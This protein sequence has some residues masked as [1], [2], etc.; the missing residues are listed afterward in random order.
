MSV[1]P[2]PAPPP[3]DCSALTGGEETASITAPPANPPTRIRRGKTGHEGSGVVF[4]GYIKDINVTLKS[5]DINFHTAIK[6]WSN[7]LFYIVE[8]SVRY[9]GTMF[10]EYHKAFAAKAATI[11]SAACYIPGSHNAADALS[12]QQIFLA[13]HIS[14]VGSHNISRT[15]PSSAIPAPSIPVSFPVFNLLQSARNYMSAAL[16][17]SARSSCSTGWSSFSSFC[18]KKTHEILHLSATTIKSY[19]SRIQFHYHLMSVS[20]PILLAIPAIRLMLHGISKSSPPTFPSQVPIS[21]DIL[22][23]LMSI[24]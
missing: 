14:A 17:P 22:Q 11:L 9:G 3:P 24:L 7:T 12:G 21:S 23:S 16:A 8:L 4:H 19:I 6:S 18:A 2:L 13:S 15:S 5:R 20:S 1:L 10:Y